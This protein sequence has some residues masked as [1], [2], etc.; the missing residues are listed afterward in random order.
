MAKSIRNKIFLDIRSISKSYLIRNE[1][2]IIL[3]SIKFSIASKEFVAV[4]APD[5][6]GK[7][8]LFNC[9]IGVENVDEGLIF[10]EDQNFTELTEGEKNVFRN[11]NLGVI[12]S[13][14][15]LIEY[16]T[17]AE[18]IELGMQSNKIDNRS[19]KI[20]EIIKFLNIEDVE[21]TLV[22]ELSPLE[23][24]KASLAKVIAKSPKM[25][26]LDEPDAKLQSIE[27]AE[28]IRLLKRIHSELQISILIFSSDT[29]IAMSSGRVIRM[30]NGKI[31]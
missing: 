22:Q 8:T 15:N 3:S 25:L 13:A 12:Y 18:N 19:V 16:L 5:G 20:K 23:N 21:N 14:N 24:I 29:K 17:V 28:L 10:Y 27:K 7:S 11:K 1:R 30:D 9:I 4:I 6:N 31:I 26:I 2:K